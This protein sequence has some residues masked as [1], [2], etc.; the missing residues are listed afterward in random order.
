MAAAHWLLLLRRSTQLSALFFQLSQSTNYYMQYVSNQVQRRGL[1]VRAARADAG[2]HAGVSVVC[3]F[4]VS[5]IPNH[6]NISSDFSACAAAPNK[7]CIVTGGTGTYDLIM[8]SSLQ[9]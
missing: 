5:L 3:P 9:L 1:W 4:P 6:I 7:V 2:E 8:T